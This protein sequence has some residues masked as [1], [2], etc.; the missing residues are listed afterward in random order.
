MAIGLGRE[1]MPGADYAFCSFIFTSTVANDAF[2]CNQRKTSRSTM[3][4]SNP[5]NYVTD[6][7]THTNYDTNSLLVDLEAT[8]SRKLNTGEKGDYV[9]RTNREFTIIAAYSGI[10][11]GLP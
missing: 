11:S 3:P 7:S 1:E 4:S 10:S 9:I 8:F 6:V 2:W 5:V